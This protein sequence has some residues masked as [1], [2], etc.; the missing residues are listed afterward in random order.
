MYRIVTGAYHDDSALKALVI[1][2]LEG[3]TDS[4]QIMLYCCTYKWLA[5]GTLQRCNNEY[6]HIYGIN[7]AWILKLWISERFD[8]VLR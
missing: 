8:S 2:R 1:V 5:T 7:D 6:L 4:L 3:L